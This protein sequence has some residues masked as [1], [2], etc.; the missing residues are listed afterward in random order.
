[1]RRSINLACISLGA[2]LGA[3]AV[4]DREPETFRI[5]PICIED[6]SDIPANAWACNEP[7]VIDCN[8]SSVPDEIY[9]S[10]DDGDCDD[11]DLEQI[12][13]PFPPGHYDIVVV[14]ADSDNAIC[15]TE[16]TV[17]DTLP[18]EIETHEVSLWP[19]NHKYH[20]IAL[21]DCI[22][23]VVDCDDNW[24]AVIDFVSSDEPG[25]D[26]GDGNTDADIVL[27][28]PDAVS[29]RSERQGGS[30]GRV[31][32]I[33]F[34]VTDGSGNATQTSCRVVVDHDQG[35]KKGGAIDDGEAYRVEPD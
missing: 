15:T 24:T 22:D 20:D 16:L 13:G 5:A 28:A 3:C 31:Y 29:L 6:D 14:D 7:L 32:T 23:E 4:D 9:V 21:D 2:A 12:P 25:N 11:L 26:N 8:D 27:V 19:P 17:T 35:K 18:P 33:G 30:N 10:V 34:T 1:M